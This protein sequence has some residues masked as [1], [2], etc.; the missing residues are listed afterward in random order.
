MDKYIRVC[1][2]SKCLEEAD[3]WVELTR[4]RHKHNGEVVPQ[5]HL[6]LDHLADLLR[7]NPSNG[8][9]VE[10]VEDSNYQ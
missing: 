9:E 1:E 10:Y 3:V 8:Y 2:H 4:R 6:C 7:H 5:Q